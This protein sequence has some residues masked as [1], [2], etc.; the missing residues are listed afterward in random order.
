VEE[1]RSCKWAYFIAE[2]AHS[3]SNGFLD[4][5]QGVESGELESAILNG[6]PLRE[7]ANLRLYQEPQVSGPS[8][9]R[10]VFSLCGA[11]AALRRL[12]FNF[13]IMNRFP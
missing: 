3:G 6:E 13:W 11:K 12:S 4:N 1:S 9:S 10:D 8:A 2:T 7:G 5:R